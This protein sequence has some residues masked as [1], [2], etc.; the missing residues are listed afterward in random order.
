MR[1]ACFRYER[2]WNAGFRWNRL[3]ESATI[4]PQEGQKFDHGGKVGV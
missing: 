2:L 3:N 1:D 4:K